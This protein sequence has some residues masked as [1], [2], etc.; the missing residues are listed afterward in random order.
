[1][2]NEHERIRS[3]DLGT[4]KVGEKQPCYIVAEI[5]VNYNGDLDL[6]KRCIDKAAQCGADA[7]KFQT[8]NAQEFVSDRETTFTYGSG[9]DSQTT[10]NL[11]EM[12]VRL[13]LPF[14]WHEILQRQA[15]EAQV[16]FLSTVT[17]KSSADL[18]LS[19]NPPALK[20]ASEDLINV[21]LLEYI[22]QAQ[23]PVI[24]STGMATTEEIEGAFRI[25]DKDKVVL[26]HC[27]SVYPT[28]LADCN[29]RRITALGEH[30]G[31]PV[32]FSDHS[33]GYQAAAA[34]VALGACVI[35]KHFTLD[36]ALP[37]PDH[38]MSADPTTFRKM[39]ESV[40]MT[41]TMLGDGQ[42]DF[43]EVELESREEGRRSIVAARGICA[44]ET[45][46]KELLAYKWPGTGLKPYE[47]E[48]IV[49][50]KA[51]RKIDAD[52]LILPQD[53]E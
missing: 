53:V 26:L 34:A 25:L 36:C 52:E 44:G 31:V 15:G 24:M 27:V 19:L 11:Y 41:E 29:L 38:A 13:Q 4:R 12:F 49:G 14:E 45:I 3:V 47:R 6:A 32:G 20:I 48:K 51:A 39:V 28:E 30:F 35:E 33:I 7:V 21:E 42:I 8:F 5:G 46:T 22:A 1:M 10:E 16:E 40:R 18:L 37:G 50:R 23:H 9:D 2:R 17:D 43:G